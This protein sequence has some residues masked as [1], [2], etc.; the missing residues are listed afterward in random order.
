MEI[1][2]QICAI[3]ENTCKSVFE[4]MIRRLDACQEIGEGNIYSV[5]YNKKNFLNK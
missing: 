3:D 5:T 2:V 1:E 4:N